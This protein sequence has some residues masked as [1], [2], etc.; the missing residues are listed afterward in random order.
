MGPA[1]VSLDQSDLYR[2][3]CVPPS[4]EGEKKGVCVLNSSLL[5]FCCYL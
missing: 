3:P 2:L 5:R 4:L 1:T